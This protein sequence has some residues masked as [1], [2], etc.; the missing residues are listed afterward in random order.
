MNV[1]D[2]DRRRPKAGAPAPWHLISDNEADIAAMAHAAAKP[3][4]M[5][6]SDW[7]Q[8][9]SWEYMEAE[10]ESSLTIL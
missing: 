5:T 9:K 1:C 8:F 7:S 4:L 2:T 6:I 10:E 3:N